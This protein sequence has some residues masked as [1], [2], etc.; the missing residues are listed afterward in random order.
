MFAVTGLRYAEVIMFLAALLFGL[1]VL[2]IFETE[3]NFRTRPGEVYE[4]NELYYE[5]GKAIFYAFKIGMGVF[6]AVLV[7]I[8]TKITG[9][10]D[11]FEGHFA[12]FL[13]VSVKTVSIVVVLKNIFFTAAAVLNN[14]MLQFP[15]F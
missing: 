3:T 2:D 13:S 12:G 8:T 10:I 5:Y 7:Y 4:L 1:N 11:S 15:G 6:I 14:I 9:V